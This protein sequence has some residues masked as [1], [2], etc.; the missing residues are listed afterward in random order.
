MTTDAELG[1]GR[2]RGG[3]LQNIPAM[4]KAG[5]MKERSAAARGELPELQRVKPSAPS[6]RVLH[7]STFGKVA[8]EMAA[9]PR[10][11]GGWRHTAERP[12]V[13]VKVQGDDGI[14]L[15]QR[16]NQAVP[17]CV[18]QPQRGQQFLSTEAG[19]IM[20]LCLASLKLR[21]SAGALL[22]GVVLIA[23]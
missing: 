8:P 14:S 18:C 5:K 12:R 11:A 4:H 23:S 6:V 9:T 2:G 15:Q 22:A 3:G 1:G 21:H 16:H 17:V 7:H 13:D 19:G 10:N 20:N